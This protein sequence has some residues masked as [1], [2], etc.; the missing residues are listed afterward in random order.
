[1]TIRG[2]IC[3][4]NGPEE[5]N[6]FSESTLAAPGTA[7]RCSSPGLDRS[8]VHM[9]TRISIFRWRLPEIKVVPTYV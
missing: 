3:K 1:M 2:L 6:I 7:R 5:C 9:M 8:Y 4:G